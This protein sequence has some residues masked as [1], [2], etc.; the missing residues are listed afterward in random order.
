MN[1][2]VLLS[3]SGTVEAE[4]AANGL[5]A[6]LELPSAFSGAITVGDPCDVL[7]LHDGSSG[8]AGIFSEV[9]T[10]ASC[11]VSMEVCKDALEAGADVAS[12]KSLVEAATAQVTVIVGVQAHLHKLAA[13]LGV[14]APDTHF[15][16]GGGILIETG[17][18]GGWVLAN[19]IVHKKS[20]WIHGVSAYSE[21]AA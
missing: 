18:A 12:A 2:V 10:K 21:A 15:T 13:A 9:L 19:V 3:D 4:H 14:E 16:P 20:W 6:Y 11:N 7:V 1:S 8:T 5:A 17:D